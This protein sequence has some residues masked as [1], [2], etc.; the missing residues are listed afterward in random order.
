MV[1][2][3]DSSGTDLHSLETFA[4]KTDKWWYLP[5]LSGGSAALITF[6][7]YFTATPVWALETFSV[8][9]LFP[10]TIFAIP[11]IAFDIL[12]KYDDGLPPGLFFYPP[13]LLIAM[14][15]GTF[16]HIS[17]VSVYFV[18]WVWFESDSDA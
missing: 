6:L 7:A 13:L 4:A 8:L 11:A 2:Q 10:A 18:R 12:N 16:P 14:I 3:I 5:A 15:I 9:F 1:S 17:V